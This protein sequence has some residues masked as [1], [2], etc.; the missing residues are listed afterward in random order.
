MKTLAVALALALALPAAVLHA[1]PCSRKL[2][3]RH[4]AAP[5]R[6]AADELSI[7]KDCL[8]WESSVRP[9]AELIPPAEPPAPPAAVRGPAVVGGGSSGS[10]AEAGFSD[11]VARNVGL[12]PVPAK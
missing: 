9:R 1:N 12:K 10:T 11:F 7:Q 4:E 8:V 2:G 5:A 6:G 3:G